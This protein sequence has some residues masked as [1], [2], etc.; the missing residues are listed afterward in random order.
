MLMQE[1]TRS[2]RSQLKLPR[3]SR[4][5][6][7]LKPQTRASDFGG[8]AD[9]GLGR[10]EARGWLEIFPLR[11]QKK[12]STS[13]NLGRSYQ[14]VNPDKGLR[15]APASLIA[16]APFSLC[17]DHYTMRLTP[18]AGSGR[19]SRMCSSCVLQGEQRG[20]EVNDPAERR[21]DGGR[22]FKVLEGEPLQTS[23]GVD[24]YTQIFA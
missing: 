22:A 7:P 5:P 20:D 8:S 2:S 24:L 10:S 13:N 12:A 1:T 21:P 23:F 14:S 19:S 16:G 17:F 4:L 9:V 3:I 11:P 6:G 15:S 18:R